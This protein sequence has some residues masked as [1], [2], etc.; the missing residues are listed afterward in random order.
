MMIPQSHY[1]IV[2]FILFA[3]GLV[4]LFTR[5]NT[6]LVLLSI[7]L[8]F[9][10]V[11]LIFVTFSRSSGNLEGQIAALFSMAIA[12]AEVAVGLAIAILLFRSQKTIDVAKFNSLKD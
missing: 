6:I 2:A 9:N 12:A 4:G 5:R 10:A 1:L 8:L 7:E 11:N 3:I